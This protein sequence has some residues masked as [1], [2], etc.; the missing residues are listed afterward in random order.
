VRSKHAGGAPWRSRRLRWLITIVGLMVLLA[1]GWPLV[2]RAVSD[3][4]PA[5]AGVPLTIGLD[6][7]HS[8]QF[9]L[10]RGWI[11]R[12]AATDPK[13][14]WV[15]RRGPV[16]MSVTYVTLVKPSQASQLWPG[17]RRILRLGSSSAQLGKPARLIS[18]QGGDG[19]TG[20]V[21]VDDRAGQAVVFPA[22]GADFAIEIVSVA[23]ADSSQ[24]AR[25]AATQVV[26]SL[27][28]PAGA[29]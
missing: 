8:A 5:S 12:S 24:A 9:T 10:G 6:S 21:T 11:I 23:P 19:L 15:L 7:S 4:Q 26:R 3:N 29:R 27:R 2:S 1:A 22:V 17:L 13:Q 18:P 14:Q 28:F 16:D 20:P 25:T